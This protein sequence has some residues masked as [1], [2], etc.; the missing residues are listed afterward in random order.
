[1]KLQYVKRLEMQMNLLEA[2]LTS[3]EL[4]SHFIWTPW[5]P[6]FSEIHAQL[7]HYSF[8]N[9]IDGYIFPTYGQ[10]DACKYLIATSC[11]S[12]N[13][14]PSSTWLIQR[15][16]A[17][18]NPSDCLQTPCAAIQSMRVSKEIGQIQN[19]STLPR[20]RHKGLGRALIMK[21]LIGFLQSGQTVASL[22]VTAENTEAVCM[23]EAIGFRP[24]RHVYTE[25]II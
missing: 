14:L 16:N 20:F 3:P 12:K 11:S 13:F 24:I 4:P 7:L 25:V 1:M 2:E 19:I 6:V 17:V 15:K 22:E 9:S 5:N 23:Y 21:A 18:K 10:Y 8:Q